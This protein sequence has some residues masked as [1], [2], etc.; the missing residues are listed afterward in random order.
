MK[1]QSSTNDATFYGHNLP[2][3]RLSDVDNNQCYER[4]KKFRGRRGYLIECHGWV[5]DS[6][7]SD[8]PRFPD[9]DCR[10]WSTTTLD[11][12]CTASDGRK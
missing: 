2:G 3:K 10:R 8:R 12:R 5:W 4:A 6:S 7:P 1:Q 9:Q 11:E